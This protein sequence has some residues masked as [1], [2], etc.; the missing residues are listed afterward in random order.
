MKT[1]IV[2]ALLA[3]APGAVASQAPSVAGEWDAS[4]NTPAGPRQFKLIFQV[5]GDSLTGTVKRP[6][7]DVPLTGKLSGDQV[8]FSYTV[9]YNDSPLAITITAKVTGDTM[10]GTVDF[11][12]AAQD[13]FSAKRAAPPG[14]SP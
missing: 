2:I 5:K 12:G 3:A 7:G 8:T 4:Y 13:T 11:G 1:A 14:R 10:Q 6:A 9:I